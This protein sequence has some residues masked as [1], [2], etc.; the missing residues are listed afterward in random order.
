M[1][2]SPSYTEKVYVVDDANRV[3]DVEVGETG[4]VKL[5]KRFGLVSAISTGICT[6]NTWAALGGTIV[7]SFYDGGPTGIM[8]EF[9]VVSFFYWFVGAS[10]AE[11]ASAIP[12]S[13]GVYHW[14]AATAGRKYGTACGY[15]AGW[16]NYFAWLLTVPSTCCICGQGILYI[17]QMYHPEFTVERWQ[18]FI[19]SVI[20]CWCQCFIVMFCTKLLPAINLAGCFFIVAGFFI[21][22]V[23]CAVMPSVNGSGYASSKFVWATF[24][25][26]S[27]YLSDAVTFLVGMLNGAF[28]VGTPDCVSHMAEEIDHAGRNLPI[29]LLWQIVVGFVTA[30]AYMAAMFYAI[31][32]IDA[33]FAAG[34]I[35]P[36]GD[37][38]RQATGSKAGALGLLAVIIIPTFCAGTGCMI[39]CGRTLYALARDNAT[40]FPSYLGLVNSTFKSP[41]WATFTCGVISTLVVAIYVGT[42]TAF[43]AFVGSFVLLTTSSFLLC[44][45]PH[46]LHKRNIITPGPFWLGKWGFVVNLVAVLYMVVFFVIYCLPYSMPVTAENMNYSSVIFVGLFALVAL[47]W[48]VGA[49]KTY[50][51]PVLDSFEVSDEVLEQVRSHQS[52]EKA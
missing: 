16:L 3:I 45:V 35:F 27:G 43:S 32:D 30:I 11:L 51:G 50:K 24:N 10:I 48:F 52:L 31:S 9:I 42:T 25:N 29:V 41:L 36:L 34:S 38:Y 40:P 33:I 5:E 17:Y 19:C 14:A 23:V 26:Q 1:H 37:I 13:G 20:I 22:V 44:I 8:Y 18:I 28:A 2:P 12:A 4:E 46:M 49:R 7:T 15:F 21:S 39:T 6:G 47:W